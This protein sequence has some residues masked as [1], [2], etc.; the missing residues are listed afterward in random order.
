[1]KKKKIVKWVLFV[2]TIAYMLRLIKNNSSLKGENKVLS[3]DNK[4]LTKEL[5]KAEYYLGREVS[6]RRK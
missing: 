3:E 4:I 5:Q 1:M 6:R 2:T